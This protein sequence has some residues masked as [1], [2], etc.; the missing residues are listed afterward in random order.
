MPTNQWMEKY[1]AVK[2]RLD[3]KTDLDAYFTEKKIGGMEVGS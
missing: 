3:C 2:N 1:E